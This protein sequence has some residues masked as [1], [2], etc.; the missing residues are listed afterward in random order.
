MACFGCCYSS[1]LSE[2]PPSGTDDSS[3]SELVEL[4]LLAL[5][6]LHARVLKIRNYSPIIKL[7]ALWI[8]GVI[9]GVSSAGLWAL[10]L[11]CALLVWR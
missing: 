7:H 11:C 10:L 6:L 2:T 9:T 3:I 1:A 5:R 8:G 4:V